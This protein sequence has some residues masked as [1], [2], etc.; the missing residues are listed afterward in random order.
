VKYSEDELN[1][2]TVAQIKQLAAENG[3][4]LTKSLKA[5]IIEEFITQQGV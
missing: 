5:D 4:T 3:Y 2:M 1:S